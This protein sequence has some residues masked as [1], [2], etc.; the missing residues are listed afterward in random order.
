MKSNGTLREEVPASLQARP[1]TTPSYRILVVDDDVAIRQL[2]V[3]V[4]TSFGY[5]VDA[6]ED[7]AAGWEALQAGSYDLLITDHNMPRVSGVELVQQLRAARM[8][9]PVLLVSGTIPFEALDRNRSLQLAAT[10]LKPFVIAELL[11]T[12]KRILHSSACTSSGSSSGKTGEANPDPM[13]HGSK[14]LNPRRALGSL[15][16]S[17][18]VSRSG[19]YKYLDENTSHV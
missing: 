5:Q 12:V 14:D 18:T 9:L 2:T 6:A 4:L 1:R 15:F 8:I 19:P 11:A 16:E 17:D 10:L 3:A 7:G 13:V